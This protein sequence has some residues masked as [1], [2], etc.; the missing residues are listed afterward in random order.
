MEGVREIT[1]SRKAVRNL[2]QYENTAEHRAHSAY[3]R[4][5][6]DEPPT[7]GERP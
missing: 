4:C 6:I 7:D 5:L 1:S 2:V 3:H